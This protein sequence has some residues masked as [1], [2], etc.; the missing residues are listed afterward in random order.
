MGRYDQDPEAE[1]KELERVQY[2]D[3]EFRA[4]RR[5]DSPTPPSL[6]DPWDPYDED[7]FDLKRDR[8]E[9]F[10]RAWEHYEEARR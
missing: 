1:R 9:R 6:E 7:P 2:E 4:L 3:A 10:D 8:W 5:V